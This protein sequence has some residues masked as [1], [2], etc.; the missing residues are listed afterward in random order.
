MSGQ[1]P[2]CVRMGTYTMLEMQKIWSSLELMLCAGERKGPKMWKAKKQEQETQSQDQNKDGLKNNGQKD[3]HVGIEVEERYGSNV[4]SQEMLAGRGCLEYYGLHDITYGGNFFT[5]SNKKLRE[6][7]ILSKLDRVMGNEAWV[8]K[9]SN[10]SAIFLLEGISNHISALI[11]VEKG[12]GWGKK[13]FKYYRIWRNAQDNKDRAKN[14]CEGQDIGTKMYKIT[15][16]LK[17]VKVSLKEV[18][19]L[20]FCTIQAGAHQAYQQLILAQ[21]KLHEKLGDGGMAVAGRE[22]YMTYKW[23]QGIYDEFL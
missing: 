13:P 4:K 16:N 1:R 2:Y 21:K 14:A 22:A 6:D 9:F 12:D 7:R 18:N 5:W 17:R 8:E 19:R 3:I 23:K 10:V 20:G 15:R 11:R